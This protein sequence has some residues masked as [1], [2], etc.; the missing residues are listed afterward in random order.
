MNTEIY[1][2]S[3]GMEDW[4]YS[5]SWEG[6]PIIT[7]S[8]NPRTYGGYD[9]ERT[10]YS[11]YKDAIKSIMFL[12]EVSDDKIPEQKYLG[13]ENLD[14]LINLRH[15]A[16]F[17]KITTH[18]KTCLDELI[19]GY[20]PRILR[21]SLTLIDILQPYIITNNFVK[22]DKIVIMWNV[23]GSITVDETYIAYKLFDEKPNNEFL[24]NLKKLEDEDKIN[25]I[26]DSKSTK[27][28]GKGIWSIDYSEKDIFKHDIPKEKKFLVYIAIAKADKDFSIQQNPDPKI[29]PQLH[30]SNSRTNKDYIAK[31]AGFILK[32][33]TFYKSEIEIID[34]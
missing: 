14:C 19:D 16:F 26:L 10:D 22:E 11:K 12:L 5:A 32:G 4:A 3:G 33:R 21:L 6:S 20:V 27:L 30:L 1:P 18:K 8:C 31:N 17:N 2:V 28:N 29:P 15:N 13:R 25:K 23:G 34:P 7:K 9:P 24:D